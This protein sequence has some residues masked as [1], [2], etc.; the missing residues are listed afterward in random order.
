MSFSSR[1]VSGIRVG[2]VNGGCIGLGGI[3]LSSDKGYITDIKSTGHPIRTKRNVVVTSEIPLKRVS[4]GEI[5]I[6][7]RKVP[8]HGAKKSVRIVSEDEIYIDD[9]KLEGEAAAASEPPA[10]EVVQYS[11]S[12]CTIVEATVEGSSQFTDCSFDSI[13]ASKCEITTSKDVHKIEAL[14]STI[15]VSGSVE[16]IT[17]DKN[18]ITCDAHVTTV[19]TSNSKLT[20]T[21]PVGTM[22]G[23]RNVVT[24]VPSSKPSSTLSYHNGTIQN[25]FSASPSSSF[26]MP[27]Q[28][29][30]D[31]S[32]S[33]CVIRSD[34]SPSGHISHDNVF[35]G[36]VGSYH[37]GDLFVRPKRPAGRGVID[38]DAK[39]V[40]K[41]ARTD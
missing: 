30:T 31:V 38:I 3:T 36:G 11:F 18:T 35:M 8:I 10:T 6:G 24:F 16:S 34:V 17:G 23:G 37:N 20:L 28:I 19:S 4:N 21:G 27:I 12:G 7:E 2:T 13:T 25:T 32:P 5:I 33:G 15:K 29:R 1:I 9:I 40:K 39:S 14:S 26:S 41:E 22:G